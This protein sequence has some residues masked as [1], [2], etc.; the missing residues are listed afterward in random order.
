MSAYIN[1]TTSIALIGLLH[2]FSL[3]GYQSE[4]IEESGKAELRKDW[5]IMASERTENWFVTAA[6]G[7]WLG[8]A[9]RE[10]SGPSF[11]QQNMKN[12]FSVRHDARGRGEANVRSWLEPFKPRDSW[13]HNK[14]HVQ[15]TRRKELCLNCRIVRWQVV[16][17]IAR[18]QI[19][20]RQAKAL[21][22]SINKLQLARPIGSFAS[23]WI[24]NN[25]Q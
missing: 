7:N 19:C 21:R 4:I 25:R 22:K 18:Q 14:N 9:G 12:R 8:Q 6:R 24:I 20:C 23:A 11:A 10:P 2:N 13:I 16:V 3:R 17:I 15:L 5:I 1:D